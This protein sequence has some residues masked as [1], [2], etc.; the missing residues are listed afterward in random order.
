[1]R[2]VAKAL[3]VALAVALFSWYVAQLGPAQVWQVIAGLG[4]SAPLVLIPY[5][6]VYIVDCLAWS[7]TLLSRNASFLTRFRI[8]WAGESVNNLVPTAYVGGEAAKVML[9]RPYGISAHDGTVAA[10]VSKTA[11]TVA[12]LLFIIGASA[13]LFQFAHN[14]PKLRL[15]ILVLLIVG[16]AAVALLFWAQ[17]IG[18]FRMF[19]AVAGALPFRSPRIESHKPKLLALDQTIFGFYREHPGRFYRSTA[20]YLCGWTLD[21]VEIYLVAHLLGVP[22]T[23]PQALVVEAFTGVAKVLGM[24]LPGSVGVQESGIILMGKL[25]GLPDA[26]VAAYALIRRARELVFAAIGMLLF[27]TGRNRKETRLSSE[28]TDE[29][30]LKAQSGK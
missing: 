3:V 20:L 23:W 8:R 10:V 15:A 24:W 19:C 4:M 28:S 27:Y 13:V 18:F 16:I 9:L 26:F 12:Q 1:M 2:L 11:Q 14:E 7:Q 29:E 25:V 17:K 30:A 5:F 22:I 6:V 21:T